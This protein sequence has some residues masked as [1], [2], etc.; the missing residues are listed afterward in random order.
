VS[1]L[2]KVVDFRAA[3]DA[4][5]AD[6]GAVDG[7]V[8]ADLDIIFDDHD[9]GL[10]DFVV[11]AIIFFGI[12]ISV[13]SDL[14]AILENDIV[15]NDTELANRDMSVSLEVVPNTGAPADVNEWVDYAVFS[16]L[17]VV[18]NDGVRPNR[19]AFAN[20]CGRR[21]SG[22][23]IDSTDCFWRFIE[24]FNCVREYQIWIGASQCSRRNVR[25]LG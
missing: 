20:L 25:K 11:A 15:A 8:R 18:F 24:K 7:G 14:C 4:G 3:P 1:D 22:S 2:N 19:S 10:D 16:N 21:N 9:T 12:A 23:R 17:D 5:L 13:G 6:S